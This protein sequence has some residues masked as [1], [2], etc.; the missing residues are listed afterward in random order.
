[1]RTMKIIGSPLYQWE[2]GRQLEIIP[3][4]GMHVNAVHFS[5]FGDTESLVVK[6]ETENGMI[7]VDIPNIMLQ[8]GSNIV[9]YCVSV[10]ADCVET[11]QE[12]VF[13][14]RERPKP[15][16][17]VYTETEVLNYATLDKRL[18]KIETDGGG[19]V[20]SVNGVE[21]DENGNVHL[22]LIKGDQGEPGIPGERGS[23]GD[24]GDPGAPGVP[25]ED[26]FSPYAK[27]E[28][29]SEGVKITI[30]DKNGTT[31]A[32][33]RNGK[34]GTGGGGSAE[35]AVLYTEQDLAP[36]QQEQARTNIG[37]VSM[38]E[39][40]ELL[41]IEEEF[42]VTGELVEF[43]LDVEPGT[44]L[45]VVSKIH[46]DETWGLSDKLVLHQVSGCNVVDYSSALLPFH[47]F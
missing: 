36:E 33:V 29:T 38:E 32:E 46:R 16:D 7:V 6:P 44:E 20:K 13:S 23:K 34:D 18:R 26:G 22:E 19:T 10:S 47:I 1:M 12:C 21:P 2:I 43:D 4:V 40:E 37:A 17:Y 3:I 14:V 9:V 45:N 8:S 28:Q 35:G 30:T 11:I 39:V 24:P 41:G 5:H 31:T 42:S 27:V 25:G 15:A